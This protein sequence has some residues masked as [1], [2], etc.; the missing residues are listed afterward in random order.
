MIAP[1]QETPAEAAAGTVAGTMPGTAAGAAVDPTARTWVDVDLGR[2]ASNLR[3][4]SSL[5]A[6]GGRILMPV[7]A[8]GYGH[9]LVPVARAAR[10]A[11]AW[12]LGIAALDEAQALREAGV[13]GPIVC[14]MPILPAEA[15]RA[16]GLDVTAAITSWP[17]AEA[18]DA[19]AR[20]AGRRVPVHVEVDTGMGRA[21]VWDREAAPLIERIAELQ[22]LELEGMFTHFASADESERGHTDAQIDRF[23]ALLD[24]LAERGIR[25]PYVHVAN[26]AAALRFRRASRALVRPGIAIYGS[27]EEIARDTDRDGRGAFDADLFPPS[28]SWHA[29][30]VAVKDLQRGEPVSYHRRY[31][32][33]GAERIA[34]LGVGYG[35]GWP[36][37]LSNRGRV[38]LRGRPVPIRGAV[39]MDLT[40]VDATPFP[41]LEVG[42]VATLIGEQGEQRR[43]VAEIGRE[44]G[45]MS[46]AVLTGITQRVPRRY[47]G[48]GHDDRR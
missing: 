44:A 39:C 48:G 41:D 42:E 20:A 13:A 23:D 1:P 25:P 12:G 9:G 15:P 18:L 36:F 4:L 40:M 2:I 43:T 10:E 22:G 32:A 17:Q 8:N 28:L 37:G 31:R 14:L 27:T 21:G 29:R 7:K 16:V 45:L 19:A 30:V 24:A 38:L 6:D 47:T 26:S 33:G 3:A 11:G 35:D 46:Y 34:L 5:L